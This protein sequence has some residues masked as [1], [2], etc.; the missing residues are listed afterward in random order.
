MGNRE[1]KWE[2]MIGWVVYILL[3]SDGTLY[4]GCTNDISRRVRQHDEGRGAKYTRGRGPVRVV[5]VQR[6]ADHSQALRREASIKRLSRAEKERLAGL[7]PAAYRT[8]PRRRR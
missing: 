5:Y 3:C 6:C 4:T 7:E 2:G 8:K 1:L